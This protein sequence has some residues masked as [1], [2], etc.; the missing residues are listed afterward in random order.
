MIKGV[1]VKKL[2]VYKDERGFFCELI[3][4]SDNFS[5]GCKFAQLSHSLV[6][7]FIIL[8][9]RLVSTLPI[10]IAG[11]GLRDLLFIF[12]FPFFGHS[13]KKAIVLSSIILLIYILSGFFAF[14][15]TL[16]LPVKNKS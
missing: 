16:I 8:S 5:K 9:S 14:L 13:Y 7:F 11:I 2:I 4:K 3:K 10:S 12:V 1:G 15:T 6:I